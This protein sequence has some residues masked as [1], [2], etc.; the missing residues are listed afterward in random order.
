MSAIIKSTEAR[1]G[2]TVPF[3]FAEIAAESRDVADHA[4]QIIAQAQAEAEAIRE[5]ARA[6]GRAAAL[7]E[8]RQTAGAQLERHLAQVAA[9]LGE[10]VEQI[11]VARAQW[12]AHWEKTAI[13][14]AVAIAERLIRR[15]LAAC[16]EITLELVRESLELAAGST[17]LQVRL[18]PDDFELLGPRVTELANGLHSISTAHVVSDPNVSRGGCRVDT[19]F[20]SIDQRFESQLAR[21][22]QELT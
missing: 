10:S 6:E 13:H 19:R 12:L 16:P 4:Q 5:A 15:E 21:I 9:V 1:G 14:V 11:G 7:A 8:A 22:E 18:H 17:D 20:G 3:H 2:A